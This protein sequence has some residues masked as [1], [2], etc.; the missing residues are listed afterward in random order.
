MKK[1]KG[2]AQIKGGKFHDGKGKQFTTLQDAMANDTNCGCGVNCKEGFIALPNFISES[3]DIIG[4]DGLYIIDGQLL[5]DTVQN[6]RTT[7]QGFISGNFPPPPVPADV[8]INYQTPVRQSFPL[9]LCGDIVVKLTNVSG[10]NT[11]GGNAVGPK[12]VTIP[13]IDGW[14]LNWNPTQTTSLNALNQPVAVQ[15]SLWSFEAI[16]IGLFLTG[17][18][19]TTNEVLSIGEEIKF[20]IELCAPEVETTRSL[21]SSLQFSNDTFIGNNTTTLSIVSE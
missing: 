18:K 17:Y 7:I 12:I 9:G 2:K 4:Q 19:F 1:L 13:A 16:Y 5:I 20:A 21:S 6:V 3:G 14:T 8:L 10:I 15:N 11:P